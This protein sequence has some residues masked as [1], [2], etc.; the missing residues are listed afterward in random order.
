[1]QTAET[2]REYY[3]IT[4]RQLP[5]DLQQHNGMAR[6]FNVMRRKNCLRLMPFVRRDYYK[7]CL[8]RGN[9]VLYTEKGEVEI[10]QPAIFFSHP[11]VKFGWRN[12]PGDQE[13]YVCL[14]NEL[15]LTADLKRELKKLHKLFEDDIYSF[16]KLTEDQYTLFL[17]YFRMMADEY[18][19][20]FEYK[21]EMIL[22]ILRLIIFTTMKLRLSTHPGP[23]EE[24]Q[25]LLAGK[26][27]DLLEAQFPVD[28]PRDAI[29]LKTPADFAAKLHV[30]VNHLN[31][32]IKQITG[33]TTSQY[34]LERKM[35]EALALLKNTDWTVAEIGSCLGF[36][37]PQYFNIFFKKQ[38]GQSPG[39]YRN[40][41]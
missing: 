40:N 21:Q 23:R 18:G 3:E 2:L 1:M 7:I 16:V 22:S 37:Y 13:G 24:K 28:S 36:E 11:L 35:A 30:H 33:K 10:R 6:H 25:D 5:A 9:A 14:F 39:T 29:R 41:L 26:F 20:Q 15:Y 8:G 31:H 4:G 19:G 32:T 17:Q 27:I 38:T 34:I 12:L